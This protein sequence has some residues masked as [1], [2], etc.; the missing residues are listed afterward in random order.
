MSGGARKVAYRSGMLGM[1]DV[2]A[3]KARIA[4]AGA[5]AVGAVETHALRHVATS[6]ESP[7][8]SSAGG[9]GWFIPLMLSH[10]VAP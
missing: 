8:Q 1:A 10:G 4:I 2:N 5:T 7:Q 9:S 3:S 6:I